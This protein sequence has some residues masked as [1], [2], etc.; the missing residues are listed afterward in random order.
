ML[1]LTTLNFEAHKNILLC[2][3]LRDYFF[4]GESERSFPTTRVQLLSFFLFWGGGCFVEF[5]WRLELK[6]IHPIP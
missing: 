1:K 5:D 2:L 3:W 6:A 4:P